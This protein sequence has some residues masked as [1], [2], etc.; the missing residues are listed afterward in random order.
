MLSAACAAP[1]PD[2]STTPATPPLVTAAPS[3][4]PTAAPATPLTT[5]APA[6]RRS[7]SP[8]PAVAYAYVDAD[9]EVVFTGDTASFRVGAEANGA[10]LPLARAIVDF[11]DGSPPDPVSGS[12]SVQRTNLKIHHVFAATGRHVAT[13]TSAELCDPS[14][15]LDV[16]A[17]QVARVL[18]LATASPATATW[19][20]CTTFQLRMTGVDQGAGLGNV[21]VLFRL[22]NVSTAGCTLLG[23]PGLRLVS[24]SG[25][26]LPTDV[27]PA[28]TGEYLFP[29]IRPH[30]VALAPRAYAAFDL[31]YVDN[32]FGP[33][34]SQPFDVACPTARAVR[35]TIPQTTQYGTTVVPLGPC[36]GLLF[37]SP[38]FPGRDWISFQ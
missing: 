14:T 13:V 34:A 24:P 16:M 11:G 19:P 17:G 1:L 27:H 3:T 38:I 4:S 8:T 32:P 20:T 22:Q 15:S 26:L 30:R 35:I 21:G 5:P 12:C 9:L 28:I 7:A 10:N 29:A 33:T 18:V 31:G 23:F 25:A 2:S 36:N 37:V 6:A